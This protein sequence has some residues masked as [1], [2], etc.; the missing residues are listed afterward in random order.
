MPPMSPNAKAFITLVLATGTAVL[1]NGLL[2]SSW[3]DLGRFLCYLLAVVLA[4]GFK[5]VLPGINGTMSVNLMII[6]ISVIE[7]SPAES[8]A[9]GCAAAVVQSLWHKHHIE[10]VHVAFNAAQIAIS[11]E[12]GYWVFHQSVALLGGQLPL[13][14]M[15]TAI[16]YF[17]A[18]TIPVAIVVSLTERR[19]F[20][21][22]WTECYFWSFPHYL[23]GAAFAGSNRMV[24]PLS[25]LAS[26]DA[27]RACRLPFVPFLSPVPG[28]AGRRKTARRTNG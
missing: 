12:L 25:G 6:L 24:E 17:L 7:L 2:H 19:P 16:T 22:T 28:K 26:F 15:A 9:V 21:H 18:N 4:S 10:A 1:A 20:R 8:L 23:V 27:D 5:V 3:P 13:R 11:I 14:L